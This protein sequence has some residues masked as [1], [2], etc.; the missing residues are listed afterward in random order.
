ML[1]VLACSSAP[2]PGTPAPSTPAPLATVVVRGTSMVPAL[3][4]GD[5]LTVDPD[6]T[7][8]RGDMVIVRGV[9]DTDLVKFV[10]G[11]PGDTLAWQPYGGLSNLVVAGEVVRNSAGT[12]YAFGAARARVL[13]LYVQAGTI[14]PEAYLVL[15]D[16]PT[17]SRDATEFGLISRRQLIGRAA[18]AR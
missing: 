15:G 4:P 5:E 17:G 3:Q 9:G 7:P 16:N 1:L 11:L 10:R 2:A 6:F 14:P 13:D 8:A 12:A 18:R